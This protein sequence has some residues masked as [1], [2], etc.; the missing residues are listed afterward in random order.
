MS[1]WV[2]IED[3]DNGFKFTRFL[4]PDEKYREIKR[5]LQELDEE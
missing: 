2:L 4:I 3:E 5:E 1:F